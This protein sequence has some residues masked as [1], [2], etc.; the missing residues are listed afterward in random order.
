MVGLR[1]RVVTRT[2]RLEHGSSG[3]KPGLGA[4][5][6]EKKKD[7]QRLGHGSSGVKL[8]AGREG[9]KKGGQCPVGDWASRVSSDV[10]L[11]TCRERK[12]EKNGDQKMEKHQ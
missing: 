6:V 7:D 9:R 11:G 1:W 8:G 2:Q 3:G 10:P 4:G 5:R 12:Q